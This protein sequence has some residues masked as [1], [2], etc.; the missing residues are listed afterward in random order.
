MRSKGTLITA[1]ETRVVKD[2]SNARVTPD[3]VSVVIVDDARV[4]L[5]ILRRTLKQAGYEDVRI[6]SSG[7]EALTLLE[8]RSANLLLVDWLMPGMDGLELTRRVRKQDEA[9]NRYTYIV[10]LTGREGS[11][12]LSTAFAGGVDDFLNKSPDNTELLLRLHAAGRVSALQNA[13]LQANRELRELNHQLAT[14]NSFDLLTGLGNRDYLERTLDRL[15]RY[16]ESRGGLAGIAMVALRRPDALRRTHGDRAVEAVDTIAAARLQQ[17]VRPMDTLG[18]LEPG[19]FGLLMHVDNEDECHPN[20]FKRLYDALNLRAYKTPDGFVN[21]G[22]NV[23]IACLRASQAA[24]QPTPETVLER[25]AEA[26]PESEAIG[27]VALARWP[28]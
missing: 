4:T 24:S 12:S 11:D 14:Q 3:K 26:L 15:L 25:V 19:Q 2:A 7:H 22:F 6:A 1:V 10:L 28:G 21:A 27:R 5:E 9:N 18:R 23:A 16:V 20:A 8:E 13:L 17:A